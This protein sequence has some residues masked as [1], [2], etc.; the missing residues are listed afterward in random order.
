MVADRHLAAAQEIA[1]VF[2]DPTP[3]AAPTARLGTTAAAPAVST[4][5][6]AL[7]ATL[8]ETRW[9]SLRLQFRQ[10]WIC[11][12]KAEPTTAW[13]ITATTAAL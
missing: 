11:G 4:V 6:V 3:V 9:I 13:A 10:N 8:E 12:I 1:L 5:V 2:M 7:A